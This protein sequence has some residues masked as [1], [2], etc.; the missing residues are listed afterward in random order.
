MHWRGAW[1][2]CTNLHTLSFPDS[3]EQIGASAFVSCD[4]LTTV[5]FPISLAKIEQKAF[6]ACSALT[7]VTDCGTKKQRN[8]VTIAEGNDVPDIVQCCPQAYLSGDVNCDGVIDISDAVLLNRYLS[9]D[10]AITITDA[11]L[12][13]ADCDGTLG[14]DIFDLRKITRVLVAMDSF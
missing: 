14:V 4:D 7:S 8:A 3:L 6:D 10:T 13:N 9:E 12:T 2:D 1:F 5:T 11:N